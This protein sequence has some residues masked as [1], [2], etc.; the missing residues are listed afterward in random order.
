[1]KHWEVLNRNINTLG[2]LLVA[3]LVIVTV[4]MT[5]LLLIWP[6]ADNR[7]ASTE[8][9]KYGSNAIADQFAVTDEIPRG[10]ATTNPQ[11]Q[12]LGNNSG[13]EYLYA[14]VNLPLTTA[15]YYGGKYTNAKAG[16]GELNTIPVLKPGDKISIIRDGYLTL[17]WK[18]G[19]VEAAGPYVFASGV[20]WTTTALGGIIDKANAKFKEKYGMPMFVFDYGDRSGHGHTY[21]TYSSV[22][23]GYGYSIYRSTAKTVDFTFRLNPEISKIP[24]LANLEVKLAFSATDSASNAFAGQ[25]IGAQLYTN[26]EYLS[27]R[28]Q[29]TDLNDHWQQ[30][31][32]SIKTIT[33]QYQLFE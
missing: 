23:G 15:D 5:S 26:L 16:A 20:C 22:N 11:P 3:K 9:V 4:V 7:L 17:N 25:S 12:I 30:I 32:S 14:T 8:L 21:T 29:E 13:L 27:D 24:Q 18:Q 19:Y 2:H 1:M 31:K 10:D 33:Q 28:Y 6:Q